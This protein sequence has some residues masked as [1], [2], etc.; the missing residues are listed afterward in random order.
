VLLHPFKGIQSGCISNSP[1]LY[2]K[3]PYSWSKERQNYPEEA[4]INNRIN[5]LGRS[6]AATPGIWE[7]GCL[8]SHTTRHNS[9]QTR[10]QAHL[11]I[12]EVL[13]LQNHF[14]QL[15]SKLHI[16]QT[17]NKMSNSPKNLTEFWENGRTKSFHN[18]NQ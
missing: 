9:C 16:L 17:K 12:A 1:S 3:I 14:L 10:I 13:D 4:E 2:L 11:V 8:H 18:K 7:G 5:I 6:A 15:V